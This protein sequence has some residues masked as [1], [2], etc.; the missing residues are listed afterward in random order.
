[1]TIL[2]S[3]PLS[4]I[5]IVLD[6][7][8]YDRLGVYGWKRGT[9]PNLDAFASSA[10][11]FDRA[12]APAQWTIPSHASMFTGLP[13]ST[14]QTTQANSILDSRFPTLAELLTQH[15]YETVGFC[16]NPLVGLIDNQ[17]KR[18][19]KSFYNY[20]GTLPNIP[21][22]FPDASLFPYI[23]LWE[24]SLKIVRKVVD[25]IQNQFA[26]NT[27]FLQAAVNP[28]FVPLWSSFVNFKGNTSQSIH[29]ISQ[30]LSKKSNRSIQEPFFLF[31]NLMETHLPFNPPARFVRQFAPAYWDDPR[32]AK[33]IKNFNKLAMHW[34]IPLKQPF[35][36]LEAQVISEMYDAE[37]AYQ[38]Y[39][40]YELLEQLQKPAIRDH[41]LVII[42]ADHGEMLGEHQFMGHGF[43]VYRELIQV[44]LMIRSPGQTV[45]SRISKPVLTTRLF[46]TILS[47]AGVDSITLPSGVETA[48][49]AMSL[50][51]VSSEPE[52]E[53]IKVISEAY[54]P[55]DA[56][57]MMERREPELIEP[58]HTRQTHRAYYT[59]EVKLYS[60]DGIS[61]TLLD[62]EDQRISPGRVDETYLLET[63]I[64]NLKDFIQESRE[65]RPQGWTTPTADLSNPLI[66]QR[67]RDLGY[68]I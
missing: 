55:Q 4:I 53:R 61:N 42:T 50:L 57:R 38:D 24:K 56:I 10:T 52:R 1:M 68:M 51:A 67:M 34:L 18:G 5:L 7:H 22:D 9:T 48:P 28:L 66:E 63:L 27:N 2:P 39:L 46:H 30:Y 6:T 21:T 12:I 33:F 54:A 36:P 32:G 35:N 26:M 40:F 64:A 44:P 8:R 47:A 19:F 41:C 16:N 65:G 25:S 29:H 14:H 23:R 59:D 3:K 20:S 31:L 60:I 17:L 62:H 15:E 45:G 58:L 49:H 13:P 43:G 11:V 37:V